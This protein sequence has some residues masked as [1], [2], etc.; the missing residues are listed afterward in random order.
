MALWITKLIPIDG[1]KN[2]LLGMDLFFLQDD[3]DSLPFG[4]T[5]PGVGA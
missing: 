2:A 1:Y 3:S 5:R 4:G